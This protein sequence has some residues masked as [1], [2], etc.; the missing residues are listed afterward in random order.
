MK[1]LHLA[2]ALI[3]LCTSSGCTLFLGSDSANQ[4][5]QSEGSDLAEPPPDALV[6]TPDA[7][8]HEGPSDAALPYDLAA[9]A[10]IEDASL[11]PDIAAPPD[12]MTPDEGISPPD[13]AAKP[14]LAMTPD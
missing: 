4:Q 7:A 3:T 13:M 9:A 10:D 1:R 12:L 6:V 14:D 5:Q 8:T 2:F 11:P